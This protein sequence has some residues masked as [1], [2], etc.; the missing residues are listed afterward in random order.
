MPDDIN[1][2]LLEQIK[3][4]LRR[5]LKLGP[6]AVIADDMPFFG[7]DVD[8]DSLDMLLLVTSLEKQFGIKVPNE[9]VGRD[10]FQ[11]VLSLTRYVQE[12]QAKAGASPQA[13]NPAMEPT[14]WLSK[15]P[16]GEGFRFVTSVSEVQPGKSAKGTWNL[17]GSEDFFAGH[18]PGKPLVPGVLIAEALAQL[19]GLT[20]PEGAPAAGKLAH[21]DV[22]FEAP[23]APPVQI[24]LQAALTRMIGNLQLCEVQAS[25]G[26]TV[27]ARGTIT[28]HRA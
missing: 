7:G 17:T 1:P 5:D 9:A 19:A 6:D 8:L 2:Q 16:H 4:I 28:L 3:T 24:D 13:H 12:Q 23:I 20:A 14:D 18:F 22:R 26:G 25:V 15:L 21:V 11:N 27:V 10:V